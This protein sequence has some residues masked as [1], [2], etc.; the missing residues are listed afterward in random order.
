MIYH[1]H[2]SEDGYCL[3]C[4][5]LDHHADWCLVLIR[6]RRCR[7]VMVGIIAALIVGSWLAAWVFG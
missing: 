4:D 1:V 3:Y 7:Y 6:Q 2:R 5:K